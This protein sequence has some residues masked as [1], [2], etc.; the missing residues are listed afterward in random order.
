M[1]NTST[2]LSNVRQI[3]KLY[4]QH[5]CK[6]KIADRLGVL[7]T[8]LNYFWLNKVVIVSQKLLFWKELV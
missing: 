8:H 4:T 7:H 1:S 3:L 5:M 6:R 2:S